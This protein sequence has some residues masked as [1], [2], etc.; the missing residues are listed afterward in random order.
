MFYGNNAILVLQCDR[1]QFHPYDAF[2]YDDSQVKSLAQTL[3]AMKLVVD[4]QLAKVGVESVRKLGGSAINLS[5]VRFS[6]P[7]VDVF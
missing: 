7:N 2:Q 4:C 6:E 5:L 3:E 1:L